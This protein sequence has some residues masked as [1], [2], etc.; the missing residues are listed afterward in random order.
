MRLRHV[1]MTASLGSPD[2]G[3]PDPG[4]FVWVTAEV[5]IEPLLQ[6]GSM[7]DPYP[8][9]PPPLLDLQGNPF[10]PPTLLFSTAAGDVMPF[11]AALT[12]GS[13]VRTRRTQVA[14]DGTIT[15]T[16]PT[17]SSLAYSA[18]AR[19][20]A[21][22]DP[23]QQGRWGVLYFLMMQRGIP[24]PFAVDEAAIVN[25]QMDITPAL[26][27]NGTFSS[28]TGGIPYV[29]TDP[30]TTPPALTLLAI[31]S[32]QSAAI[33]ALSAQVT[34]LAARPSILDEGTLP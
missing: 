3:G 29:Y 23:V 24:I 11:P 31:L 27:K 9:P 14:T 21:D 17:P 22:L 34:A 30:G 15:V 13:L 28:V 6:P 26:S 4:T 25:G 12:S 16:M 7:G 19:T 5:E 32:A 8:Y 18:G 10:P 2:D 20:S 1:N 33:A